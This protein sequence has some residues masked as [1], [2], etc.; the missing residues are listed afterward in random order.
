MFLYRSHKQKGRPELRPHNTTH[1]SRFTCA[2]M[3]CCS[4]KQ[5]WISNMPVSV[6][7]PIIVDEPPKH[8]RSGYTTVEFITTQYSSKVD[9]TLLCSNRPRRKGA[10]AT[11]TGTP[12][13]QQPRESSMSHLGALTRLHVDLHPAEH[14]RGAGRKSKQPPPLPPPRQKGAEKH[15]QSALAALYER[16][17]T[18]VSGEGPA[19]P[20]P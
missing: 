20:A 15:A 1:I 2:R 12:R 19:G 11:G 8:H 7:R 13:S 3:P 6:T 16:N 10:A 18:K 14:R 17:A 4:W 9:E 5:I